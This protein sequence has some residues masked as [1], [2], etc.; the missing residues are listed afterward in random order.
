M[1][2]GG[3]GQVEFVGKAGGEYGGVYA[4]A[5]LDHQ[6]VDASLTQVIEHD[7]EIDCRTQ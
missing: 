3:D 7:T 6:P 4:G 5:A 2:S 1:S